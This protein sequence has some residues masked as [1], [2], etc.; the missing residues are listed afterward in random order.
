MD[1]RN[2]IDILFQKFFMIF[3]LFISSKF[4]RMLITASVIL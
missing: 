4:Y 1:D 3:E 2:D